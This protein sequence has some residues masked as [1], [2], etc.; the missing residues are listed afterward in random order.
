MKY[1]AIRSEGGLI[2]YDLLEQIAN[3]QVPGQ[4]PAD[5]GLPR[6]RRLSDEI[7][8]VWNDA[9]DFWD[10]FRRRMA[11]PSERDPYGTTETRERWLYPLLNDS[12]TF[13]YDLKLQPSAITRNGASFPISHLAGDSQE[14]PPVHIEGFNVDL[15][16]RGPKLRTSPRAMVQEFLNRSEQHIWGIATNGLR[17]LLLRDSART[18][19]PTYL[20]FDLETILQANL[21]HEF[22]VFYRLC[23]RSRLPR[24][25]EDPTKCLLEQYYQLSIEQ[26]GRVR[27]K[28]RD[29]VEEA[30]Q[31]LGTGFLRHPAN[32][33]LRERIESGRLTPAEYHR[34]LLRL[35][36]R[37][38]FLMVAEERRL[39]VAMGDE[40]ERR[41][42]IYDD[43]Y[44]VAR[45]RERA[46]GIV[47]QSTYSDLWIGLK[48]TFSLFSDSHD[49]NPLGIPPLNGELFSYRAITD[50]EGTQ[51][52]NH[53]LIRAIRGLSLFREEKV[54]RKVNYSALDVEELG[55]VYESLL[56]FQ[57]LVEKE[58][59]G[60]KFE[61][62]E[63]G[64]R[65]KTGSYYTRP[66]LVRELIQSALVPVIEDRL[67]EAEKACRGASSDRPTEEQLKAAKVKAILNIAVCDP[68]CG[69]GH[70]LLEA[71]RRLGR[72]LARIRTGQEEPSPEEFHLAVRDA[73]SHCIYGVD[74]NPLAVDLC[75]LALWLEGHWIG[76][77][78]SFLDHRIKSGDSL[79]G[80]LD[81]SALEKGIPDEA[82]SPVT[83]DDKKVAAAY[84]KRNKKEREM[85]LRRFDFEVGEHLPAFAKAG[86]EAMDFPENN[87][88]DVRRKEEL[89]R[90]A[91]EQKE[92]LHDWTAANLWTAAFFVPLTKHDDPVV[93]TQETF[94]DY[95]LHGKDRPQM[96]GQGNVFFFERRFFHW[97]LEFPEVFAKGGFDVVLG[98]PPWER[99]KLQEE[100][101]WADDPYI[102]TAPNKAERTRRIEEYR[103]SSDL[104]KRARV[105]RFDAAK[106]AADATSRFIRESGR[107]PL[108]AAGDI[109]TY[110]LFAELART[111]LNKQGR[112]GVILPTGI[113]TDD[114]NKQ[115]FGGLN[116]KRAVASLF[117]LE[118]REGLFPEVDS[119]MKFSLFTM[120]V[121]P[122]SA[123]TFACYLTRTEQIRDPARRFELAP[124]DFALLNPNTR[125]CPIFRTRADAELTKKIYRQVPIL[126][127]DRSN[128]NSWG[129]EYLRM[130]DMSNDSDLFR[131]EPGAGLVPLYEGKMVQ[132]YD[133]RAASVITNVQNLKR[134]GQPV[135]TTLEQHRDPNYLP[136]AQYWVPE[137]EVRNRIPNWYRYK[138][139]L[140]FK[141]VTSPTNERTFIATALPWSGVA[142]SMPLMLTTQKEA[143]LV[144]C[145]LANLNSLVFDFVARQKVGGVNLNF[146]IINQL[147]ALP[148]ASYGAAEIEF[149]SSRVLELVYAGFD[150]KAFAKDMGHEGQ[151]FLWDEDRRAILRAETDAYFAHLY[152]LTRDELRYIL[153]PKEVF[154]EDFPSE[155]F[156]VVKEKEEKEY[157]EYR[158]RRLVLAAYDEL[159]KTDRF[160]GEKRESAIEAPKGRSMVPVS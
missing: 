48:Q 82:F 106:H 94:M 45:L 85:L 7:Q 18:A 127:N 16:R 92:W 136:R 105:A 110:A 149:I 36:Y 157:G 42:R 61:L 70:F 11:S 123:T 31:I 95:L 143:K 68:A 115:F 47:E 58:A 26:G 63:G 103:S 59:E 24:P 139:F 129:I 133:H 71:A 158:T 118:N 67:A 41:Q 147:V 12:R 6:D 145:L 56:D 62:P 160:A 64:E 140:G 57:P 122:V 116:Q 10:V 2:P 101:F 120:S 117:D 102:A 107:F 46:E 19:R 151:P 60:P 146:F 156:R 4:K 39:I 86:A 52:Y 66:E 154:G 137:G 38:L 119:R 73:I 88:E 40:A 20:E 81:P 148:P 74:L 51:L 87:P 131:T 49:V 30:L 142:N 8:R 27:D 32:A 152:G 124:E 5:F 125:T 126:V 111:L 100:E 93:P 113:A 90:K 72:E 23:H 84:K 96:T 54:L 22:A 97:R 9:Q 112:A 75:K 141:S 138:W 34:Q 134:P 159:A 108:T 144:A 28:L 91:R 114:T 69:S 132:A 150:M 121:K 76:K 98:N 14:A 1:T 13:G 99:I 128:T 43:F 77:P 65:K 53:D 37:L 80:V 3:E 130:L 55:S 44:S 33:Q 155:T 109:N 17:F 78:L 79:I 35:V 29:G 21:F 50:L 25:G 89:Y 104:E 153:D 135:E 15:D 83:G